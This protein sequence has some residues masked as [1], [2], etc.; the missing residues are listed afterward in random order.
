MKISSGAAKL[1]AWVAVIVA[2]AGL[3]Y[4]YKE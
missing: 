3:I 4:L 1:A 2:V